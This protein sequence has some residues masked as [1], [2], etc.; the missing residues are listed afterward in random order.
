MTIRRYHPDFPALAFFNKHAV[1]TIARFV[2]GHG[3]NGSL[4]HFPDSRSR[5]CRQS[6]AV[7]FR[8][9]G[10]LARIHSNNLED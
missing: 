2:G 6:F 7:D 4:D 10:K 1:Q 3:E 5:R 9:L 8:E